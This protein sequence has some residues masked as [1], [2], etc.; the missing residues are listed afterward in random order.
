MTTIFSLGNP[1]TFETFILIMNKNNIV[2]E[3]IVATILVSCMVIS[4]KD[5][6]ELKNH[7]LKKKTWFLLLDLLNYSAFIILF[8][9]RETKQEKRSTLKFFILYLNFYYF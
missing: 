1:V 6:K 7:P 2:V 8:I 4:K 9:Y 5:L 3:V